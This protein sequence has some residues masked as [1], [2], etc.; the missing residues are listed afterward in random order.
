MRYSNIF[1]SLSFAALLTA[2]VANAGG[3]NTFRGATF[4]IGIPAGWKQF[5]LTQDVFEA[6][7]RSVDDKQAKAIFAKVQQMAA[8]KSIKLFAADSAGI[9]RGFANN[10]N[11]LV[12]EQNVPTSAQALLQDTKTQ[13][14]PLAPTI[15]TAGPLG[16]R[17]IGGKDYVY[18]KLRVKIAPEKTYTVYSYSTIHRYRQYTFSFTCHPN[19]DVKFARTADWAMKTVTY[20]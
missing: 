18:G 5:D 20:Q 12:T 19:D 14:A 9:K 1:K 2:S 15:T 16:I 3:T 10:L 8:N 17:K 13:L 4:S 11:V 7:N 6:A